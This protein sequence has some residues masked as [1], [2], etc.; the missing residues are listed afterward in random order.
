GPTPI[1]P[2]AALGDVWV[3]RED[4]SSPVYGGNKVRT[5]EA[6]LGRARA[7]GARTIWATGAYGS[8]HA[9]ATVMHARAAGMDAG[10]IMFPQP[11]SEPARA[12]LGAILVSGAQ[13]VR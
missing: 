4:R 7:A 8:N 5:L 13:V 9:V 10:V 11:A 6:V 2:L 3:K 1:E 12:N